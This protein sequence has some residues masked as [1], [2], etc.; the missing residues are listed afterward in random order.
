M[1]RE[2]RGRQEGGAVKRH[3]ALSSMMN[4]LTVSTVVMGFPDVHIL[5]N[6]QIL[7]CKHVQLI[8]HQQYRGPSPEAQWLGL[9]LPSHV[10][11]VQSL[12]R[13]LRSDSCGQKKQ[14]FKKKKKRSNIVTNSIKTF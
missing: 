3:G 4:M 6:V 5:K 11:L 13:E 14:T 2:D 12:V 9:C 7:H 10:V 8:I 1:K